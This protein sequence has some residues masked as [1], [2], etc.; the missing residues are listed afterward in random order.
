MSANA[1]NRRRRVSFE[2]DAEPGSKVCVVGDFN[3]WQLNK[4]FLKET[5]VRG[6]FKGGLLLHRGRYEYKFVINGVWAVDPACE[7]WIAND[8]G[9]INSVI[10]VV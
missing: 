4:K 2:L 3:A 8:F 7:D 9:S 1:L 10:N 6:H 5:G